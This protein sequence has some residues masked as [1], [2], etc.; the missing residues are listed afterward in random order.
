MRMAAGTASAA[1]PIARLVAGVD[2]VLRVI[3]VIDPKADRKA[4][5]T[6]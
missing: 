1:R 4:R 6:G 5:R 3:L 2:M